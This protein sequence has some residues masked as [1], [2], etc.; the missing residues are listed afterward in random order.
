MLTNKADWLH[1]FWFLWPKCVPM[2]LSPGQPSTLSLLQFIYFE[3]YII[4][5]VFASQM[6]YK[7]LIFTS[8][9]WKEKWLINN[10]NL[11]LTFLED[12]SPTSECQ[13]GSTLVSVADYCLLV[14][15]SYGREIVKGHNH[16]QKAPSLT[17]SL[18]SYQ[19][20][21]FKHMNLGR[22]QIFRL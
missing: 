2:S 15:F 17:V 5:C 19:E 1:W 20:S 14:M 16:T 18:L 13:R 21:W 10:R 12:E 8:S 3:D 11:F 22:T 4:F 9:F 7:M 6:T